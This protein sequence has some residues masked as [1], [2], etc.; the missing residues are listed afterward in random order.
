MSPTDA[1]RRVLLIL[2]FMVA[3]PGLWLIAMPHKEP[4]NAVL[5]QTCPSPLKF[6]VFRDPKFFREGE[7]E[8]PA[9]R[10]RCLALSAH[11]WHFGWMLLVTGGLGA[12]LA[13]TAVRPSRHSPATDVVNG[14]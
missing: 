12:A 9:D 5:T 13:L 4:T 10:M 8:F 6:R 7:E 1:A 3:F 14:E 2:A 11:R